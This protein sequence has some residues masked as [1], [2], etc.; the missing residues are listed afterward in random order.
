MPATASRI[1]VETSPPYGRWAAP[2]LNG[3]IELAPSGDGISRALTNYLE[4]TKTAGNEPARTEAAIGLKSRMLDLSYESL[5]QKIAEA[6]ETTRRGIGRALAGVQ[7]L[8]LLSIA[9]AAAAI[10]L[11]S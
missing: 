10:G 11:K 4:Q 2:P 7:G 3:L 1:L 9:I 6:R 5:A 8:T